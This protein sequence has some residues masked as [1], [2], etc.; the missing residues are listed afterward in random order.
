[1]GEHRRRDVQ[2]VD[3]ALGAAEQ[4]VDQRHRL[5]ERDRRQLDAVDD[6]ADGVDAG[7]VGAVALVDDAPRR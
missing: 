7:H 6:V 5:G 1:M 4:V 3:V 2:V